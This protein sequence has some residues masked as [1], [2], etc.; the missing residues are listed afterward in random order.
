MIRVG[1]VGATGYGGREL[2][3]LLAMHPEVTLSAVASESSPGQ[4]VDEVLPAFRKITD[5]SFEA[6]DAKGLAKRCD[7]V[8]I[9][10]PGTKSMAFGKALREAGATVMD[11]GPDFRLKDAA[12]FAKYHKA[13]HSAPE[14]LPE[15]VYGLAPVH[16]EKLRTANLVAVP[17]CYPISAILPLWPL[18]DAA[19][20]DVPVVIDSISG[21]SGAGKSLNEAF[22]FPE[23]NENL[24]AYKLGVHQ[25]IPEIEQELGHKALVQFTPHVAPLTRGILTTITLRPSG[26]LD[27]AALYE[28]YRDEPFVRVLGEGVLPEVKHVRASNF[29]DIGWVMDARTGNLLVVSAIDNLMGG[30]AGM[31]VQCM[32]IRFG[33]PETTGLLYGGMAP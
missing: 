26:K 23:M 16:R 5:L 6:F 21:I 3:R 11:I 18:L 27:A 20:T 19:K 24:K 22:H 25:H 15:S 13:T 1:I 7:V 29:C 14:L 4:R 8:F 31:A 10:V 2:L 32:N 30:T 9:G 33:L 12:L 28:C 17:G